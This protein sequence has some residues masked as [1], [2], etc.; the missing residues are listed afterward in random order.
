MNGWVDH[1]GWHAADGYP[2]VGHPSLA[3]HC[4]C[5]RK[6]AG[7]RPTFYP[8]CYI[9]GDNL[10]FI[11]DNPVGFVSLKWGQVI[12]SDSSGFGSNLVPLVPFL[13]Q[14][15]L[16]LTYA[17]SLS[18]PV[19]HRPQTTRLHPALSCTASSIFC[20]LVLSTAVLAWQCCH[21]SFWACDQPSSTFSSQLNQQVS[22]RSSSIHPCWIFCLA[23]GCLRFFLDIYSQK[24]AACLCLTDRNN[25][26]LSP[27]ILSYS[28]MSVTGNRLVGCSS[29]NILLLQCSS[30]DATVKL[31]DLDTQHCFRTVVGHSREV[32]H[33]CLS[34]TNVLQSFCY[35]VV[36]ILLF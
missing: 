3:R 12:R 7:Q 30:K 25:Y 1:V 31:W 23:S 17:L 35:S 5:Q 28:V 8:L 11:G 22:G 13:C 6:F 27:L 29:L 9:I 36:T 34:S 14:T 4:A 10:E 20:G 33:F 32:R 21:H 18:L 19:E 26:F 15:W 2:Q 24:L 16:D